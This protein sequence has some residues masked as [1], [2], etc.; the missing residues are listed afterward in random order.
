[1]SGDGPYAP[2]SWMESSYADEAGGTRIRSRGALKITV[3]PFLIPQ[4]PVLRRVLGTIDAEDQRYLRA[5]P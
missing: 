4:G 2:G 5:E 1:M 3:V